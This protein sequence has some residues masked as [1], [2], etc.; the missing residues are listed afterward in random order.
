[1]KLLQPD[2]VVLLIGTN[3]QFYFTLQQYENNLQQIVSRVHQS[4]AKLVLGMVPPNSRIAGS[5]TAAINQFL[6]SLPV[7]GFIRF[8]NTLSVN[9]DG[10]TYNQNLMPDGT[11]PNAQGNL[12]MFQQ[13]QNDVPWLF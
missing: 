1:M 9:N 5:T 7:E 10:Q 3:D 6:L 8:D 13:I 11:H 12:L 2:V 4:G